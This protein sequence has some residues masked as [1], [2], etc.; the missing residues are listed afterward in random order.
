MNLAGG[1]VRAALDAC[2]GAHGDAFVFGF[3][4]IRLHWFLDAG[5]L[6]LR[7]PGRRDAFGNAGAYGFLEPVGGPT[8]LIATDDPTTCARRRAVQPA[9]HARAAAPPGPRRPRRTLRA[10]RRGRRSGRGRRARAGLRPV[11]LEVVLDVL[12]GAATRAAPSAAGRGRRGDDGV[13]QPADAGAARARCRS[14]R[15]PGPAS[16]PPAGARTRRCARHPRAAPRRG[17][18]SRRRPGAADRA[19]RRSRGHA[20]AE[21][22]LRDQALSLV[23]AGFDTTTAA[24]AWLTYLLARDDLRDRWRRSWRARPAEAGAR[25]DHGRAC[26][27]RACAS[28]RRRPPSCGACGA[29]SPGGATARRWRA[30]RACRRG[31]CTGT[32]DLW[33]EPERVAPQRWLDRDGAVGGAA[34]PVRVP[35][36]RP[37]RAL[38]HRCGPR[39]HADDRLRHGRRPRRPLGT[40]ARGAARGDDAGAVAWAPAA[41]DAGV[42]ARAASALDGGRRRAPTRRA[43][44]VARR[45]RAR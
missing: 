18:R 6:P 38:L 22:E 26:C 41:L 14:R 8:A 21:D 15:R 34:R 27:R 12:L 30:R 28:T 24:I 43:D 40:H 25:A 13:R 42:G 2:R 20:L 29:E 37:R 16:S 7:A 39:A 11:V 10:L 23:S 4:P 17:A 9:F 36:V 33:R 35:P 1:D 32:R 44:R 3:G 45:G 5:R 31:T 19:R